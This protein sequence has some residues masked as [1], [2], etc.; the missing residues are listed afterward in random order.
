LAQQTGHNSAELNEDE[1]GVQWADE[2]LAGHDRLSMKTMMEAE[3]KLVSGILAP[4]H[5]AA[6]SGPR[7]LSSLE[8]ETRWVEGQVHAAGAHATVVEAVEAVA[9]G[10]R[11]KRSS[12][13]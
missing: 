13:W 2:T 1:E 5:D 12:V 7:Q 8:C 3:P 4:V 9:A 6:V 11:Q 10:R